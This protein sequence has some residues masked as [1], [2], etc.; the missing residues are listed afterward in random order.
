LY[1]TIKEYCHVEDEAKLQVATLELHLRGSDEL[2]RMR[3]EEI[4]RFEDK[5]IEGGPSVLP[6]VHRLIDQVGVSR[7]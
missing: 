5:V 7:S 1:D 3:Q 2:M 4:M 6:G